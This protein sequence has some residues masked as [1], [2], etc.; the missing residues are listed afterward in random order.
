VD[1]LQRATQGSKALKNGAATP[2]AALSFL[3]EK[4]EIFALHN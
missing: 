3:L 1:G 4:P 2:A